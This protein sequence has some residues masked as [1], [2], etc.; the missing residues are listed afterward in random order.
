VNPGIE[1]AYESGIPVIIFDR[2]CTTE[3]YTHF[4]GYSDK[5]NGAEC[6]RMLVEALTERYG[7]PKGNIIALDT[8]A[9]SSTDNFQKE[10]QDSVFSQYPDIKIIARQYTDFEVSKGKSFMEDCLAKFGSGEID[11]FISQDGGVTLGAVDAINEAGRDK[12]NIIFTNADGING[13]VKLI[14]DGSCVGV[15]QFPCAASV[16]A[17][18]MAIACIEGTDPEEKDIMMDSI[19]VTKDNVDEYLIP[20]GDDYDWTY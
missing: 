1:A 14:Q 12:D 10:G 20:D 8:I 19:V 11:G 7:E 5:Q 18:H 15:T 3:D 13:V 2:T 17:L 9:G 16:D 6:A 4:V